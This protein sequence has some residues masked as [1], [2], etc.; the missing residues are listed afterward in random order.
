MYLITD[1]ELESSKRINKKYND[2]MS[3]FNI[4]I[5]FNIIMKYQNLY[6][7]VVTEFSEIVSSSSYGNEILDLK[8]VMNK[9]LLL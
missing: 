3:F 2:W 5:P 8:N 1:E 9:F 4:S 6:L 7:K